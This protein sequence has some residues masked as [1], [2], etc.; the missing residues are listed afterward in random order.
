MEKPIDSE[1]PNTFFPAIRPFFS[2]TAISKGSSGYSIAR[3]RRRSNKVE[4]APELRDVPQGFASS[5]VR[6]GLRM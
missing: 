3:R 2:P 6:S 5:G 4:K 1:S